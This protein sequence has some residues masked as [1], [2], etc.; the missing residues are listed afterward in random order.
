MDLTVQD[1]LVVLAV[2]VEEFY[3]EQ[4]ALAAV[5]LVPLVEAAEQVG[6]GQ[7]VLHITSLVLLDLEEVLAMLA[8][9]DLAR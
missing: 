2:V 8:A 1:Q 6:A 7:P 5:P 9:T 3:Q 4:A